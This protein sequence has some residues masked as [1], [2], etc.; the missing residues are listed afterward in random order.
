MMVATSARSRENTVG[1][2][3]LRDLL[4]KKSVLLAFGTAWGLDE[5]VLAAADYVLEPVRGE[6]DYNHLPVRSAVSIILD[7]LIRSDI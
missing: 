7:R 3:F 2:S 5:T 1:F 4:K 6:S